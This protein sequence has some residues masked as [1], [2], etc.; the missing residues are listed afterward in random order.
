MLAGTDVSPAFH[1]H[2]LRHTFASFGILNGA[3][4]HVVQ[5]LLGHASS[6][7]TLD[8]YAHAFMEQQARMMNAPALGIDAAQVGG[9][10]A[11]ASGN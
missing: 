7:M 6:Q 2:S 3:P 4:V 10:F 5:S 9:M 8:I 1:M 11:L